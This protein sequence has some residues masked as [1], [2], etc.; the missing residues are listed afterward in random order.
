MSLVSVQ[1]Y[2]LRDAI[3]DDLD[4]AVARVREIGYEHVEPY[5]FVERVA[6]F[7]R[8]LAASG[9]TAPSG[10]AAVIDAPDPD[11]VFEAAARLGIGGVIDPFVPAD[12]WRTAD[13]LLDRARAQAEAYGVPA[14]G[15]VEQLLARDDIELVVNL[16]VPAVH[17]EVGRR[18]VAAGKHVGSEKPLATDHAS[19]V[20]LLDAAAAHDLPRPL[21]RGVAPGPGLPVRP[22]RRPSVRHGA[23]LR[24]HPGARPGRGDARAGR[25][26]E[27]AR[28]THD[29]LG[30]AG[31]RDV[32][33]RGAD[34]PRGADPVPRRAVGAVDVLLPAR[35]AARGLRGDQRHARH[36]LAARPQHVRGRLHP[37]APR[38]RRADDAPGDRLDVGPR[39]GRR[40]AA[41]AIRE[42]RPERASGAVALHVLDVLLATRDAAETG[43][44]V[45]VASTVDAVPPLPDDFDPAA[46]TF[47]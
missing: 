17:T 40:R 25:L 33:G 32:P 11:V 22:G 9:L 47:A 16:T 19:A 10:H 28:P 20:E 13:L 34:A 45:E 44:A 26:L 35:P 15:T 46:A 37:L 42:G 41:R 24:D 38:G 23:V 31:G 18:I 27:V 21:P 7:E 12:R 8:A 1:L 2:S 6:D 30:P 39:H 43:S 5:A 4:A 14:H 36:D 29:R 3:T